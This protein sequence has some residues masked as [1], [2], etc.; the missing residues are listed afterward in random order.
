MSN[1]TPAEILA[2][3]SGLT[4]A[5]IQDIWQDAKANQARLSG[6]AGHTF[7]RVAVKFISEER[8]CSKCGGR[9]RVGDI[10]TYVRGYAASGGNPIDV[11]EVV[12]G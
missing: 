5:A 10:Q 2:E 9:M 6:C 12:R 7:G 1:R 4:P 3:A 8:T 11:W